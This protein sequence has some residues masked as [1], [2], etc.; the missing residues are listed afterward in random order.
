LQPLEHI[1][2]SK[3]RGRIMKDSGRTSPLSWR[4]LAVCIGCIAALLALFFAPAVAPAFLRL[5]HWTADW[6][7]AF[8]S[9]RLPATHPEIA[10]VLI[11]DKTLEPYPYLLPPDRALLA[12][13]V[14]AVP[15]AGA[16]AIGLDFY[17]T[18]RTEPEKDARLVQALQQSKD[19][20]V[21]GS[22]ETGLR[23]TQV[24]YEREFIDQVGAPAGFINLRTERDYVIRYRAS[25]R[26]DARYPQSFS[27]A[28]SGPAGQTVRLPP[29]RIAWLLP[30]SDGGS[31]FLRVAADDLLKAPE[32][33]GQLKGRVVLIGGEFPFLDQHWTPLSLRSRAPM[34]GVEIHAQMIAEMLDGNRSFS[35]LTQRQAETFL[36]GLSALGLALGLRFR[37][38]RY[39]YLDWR[40]AS[41]AV[42][43]TDVI[44]FKFFHLIL[45]F[46]L[47]A[48]AW[49]AG[50]TLGTQ[51]P[52]AV[53]WIRRRDVT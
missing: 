39:N 8:L 1:A 38:R 13:V 45:P 21:L 51:L 14:T 22:F 28:L 18:K 17:F 36:A 34:S 37:S 3:G 48:V 31:T 53:A 23:P 49:I 12:D 33:A 50:V 9:D 4:P 46:T 42:I 16:R 15:Q 5:E 24:A 7:T 41:I 43:V 29:L 25:S 30:P 32:V 47:A 35:E 26:S 52:Q 20:L 40:V 11:T 10:L 44:I 2:Q 19:T 27:A 6:R